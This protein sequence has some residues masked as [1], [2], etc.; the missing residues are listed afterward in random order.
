MDSKGPLGGTETTGRP[1]CPLANGSQDRDSTP[2]ESRVLVGLVMATSGRVDRAKTIDDRC[3][4]RCH[5]AL[6]LLR[7]CSAPPRTSKDGVSVQTTISLEATGF[8]RLAPTDYGCLQHG[9]SGNSLL[10]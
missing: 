2:T 6:A 5:R 9:N 3:H 7:S 8:S 1:A 10:V 4:R